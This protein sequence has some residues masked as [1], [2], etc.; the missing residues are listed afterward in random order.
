M[1]N[2]LENIKQKF[3]LVLPDLSDVQRLSFCWFST[4]CIP[5]D[6]TDFPSV[7]N[8]KSG[9]ELILYG[10][11]YEIHYP[12]FNI[13]NALQKRGNFNLRIYVLLS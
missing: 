8:K 4:E 2:K 11:E 13:L 5:E 10:Q 9:I 3:P 1:K 12:N 6:L 7:L